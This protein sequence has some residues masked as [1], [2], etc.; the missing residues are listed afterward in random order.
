MKIIVT[1]AKNRYTGVCLDALQAGTGRGSH[2]S[3]EHDYVSYELS[4]AQY[5]MIVA[6]VEK[7]GTEVNTCGSLGEIESL[8]ATGRYKT[9]E[10][11]TRGVT[12]PNLRQPTAVEE[13][14]PNPPNPNRDV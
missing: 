14:R 12:G 4:K 11:M 7:L 3:N 6:F 1:I 13:H 10:E 9:P 2:P 5:D 8:P